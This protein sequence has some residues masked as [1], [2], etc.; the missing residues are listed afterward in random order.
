MRLNI[1][2][3]AFQRMSLM[4]SLKKIAGYVQEREMD[5]SVFEP[6]IR[7]CGAPTVRQRQE[8]K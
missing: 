4:R 3:H 8:T 6:S 7:M 2:M 5:I 1:H